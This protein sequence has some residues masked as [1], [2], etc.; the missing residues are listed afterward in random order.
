MRA[1]LI[2]ALLISTFTKLIV[3]NGY[4]FAFTMDQG[5]DMVDIRQMVVS[6]TP[7]LVGPTTSIN[8]VLLGPFWY[9]FLLPPFLISGGNPQAIMNWQIIWYQLSA[10]LLWF[11]I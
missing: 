5:R 2:L 1:L 7:K 4:N 9:Y 10:L 3:V 6:L 11:V 8:G